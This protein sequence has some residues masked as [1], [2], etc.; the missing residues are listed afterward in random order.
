MALIIVESPTKARTFNRIL[1]G[2]DYYVYAT[3]GHIR[4]LPGAS[5]AIDFKNH[6]A[7]Q[8][9][10]IENKKKVVATLK[11]LAKKNKEI[12][13]ATDLDREGESIS[14][15]AACILGL[16]NED[17][18]E[19]SVKKK[20]KKLTRI[21]FH[22]ITSNALEEALK[23]PSELRVDLI[24]AQ[25]ARRILDRIVGYELSPLLW[26]K[27]GKNW[28]SAGRVQTVAL[29]LIVEREKEIRKF[30]SEPYYQIYTLFNNS[31]LRAK[32][33]EK[34]KIPYEQTI[35][36]VLFAGK[37]Q[38]SRTTISESNHVQIETDLK[39][40]SYKIS[41]INKET[42]MRYPPPPLTTSL[43]QQEGFYKCNFTSRTV[44][45]LAQDLYE[46]G[47]I[48]YHRTDSFNLSTQF[49]FAAQRYIKSTYG[50]KYAL[51]KPRG[52]R[53]KSK[54]AQEAHEAIRPTKI[55]R[56]LSTVKDKS[57]TANHKKLYQL[58][59]N[60]AV[61]TQMKEA[62]VLYSKLLID[63]DKK[64]CLLSEHQQVIFPGFLKI[65]NPE[66][67]KMHTDAIQIN[68]GQSVAYSDLESKLE[69][70]KP[71]PRYNDASLIKIM[72]EKSIGRPSTYAPI[73][74]LIQTKGYVE[75]DGRYFKPTGLG[76]SICNY[77][78]SAFSELFDINFTAQMEDSLD[79]IANG[80]QKLI[81]ILEKFY[82]PFNKTLTIQKAN[83]EVI[84]IVEEKHGDCD[85]CGKPMIQRFSR[86]GKFLACSG[87]PKCKNIKA[88]LTVVVGQKCPDCGGDVVVRFTKSK[89][90]FFGC[91]NYPK[92]K[93]SSW[94]I[95]K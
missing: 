88:F 23:N 35:N 54:S 79:E 36:I 16:I 63:S 6:F 51:E 33:I 81:E 22:E 5:M 19:F 62:E 49:V 55:E 57:I 44:M 50:E 14:Y 53:T 72:E 17:W 61:A 58:I 24:K 21:V 25:Q 13:F 73:I 30:A 56:E 82:E 95:N 27:T 40:D 77:L 93:H 9:Q 37:Y 7:P 41:A 1:K 2:K 3:M 47:L 87:Y 20:A 38:Y 31:L 76:E 92:C 80:N 89:R 52:Y 46:H 48:T 8:Y 64:Y 60:R 86:F 67:V 11:D 34:D 59:W 26:K 74:G 65:L 83:T 4:D 69:Q 68:E 28:L 75:K 78:S 42:Q 15:H 12:I 71:P 91:S 29:R 90:R 70:T 85:K 43:L 10:I 18:P 94:M 32:L 39:T 45:K 66:Y 84:K